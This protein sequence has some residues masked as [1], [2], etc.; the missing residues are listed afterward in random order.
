MDQHETA[1]SADPVV[2]APP[3]GAPAPR[4]LCTDC[5][6]SRTADAKRCGR[7]CQF[8]QPDYPAMETKVHGRPR[9]AARPD[10]TFFGPV[11]RMVRAE[12]SPPRLGAQWTG[13][14][15]RIAERLLET[16]AVEAVLTMAPDPDDSWK[17]MPVIIT[18]AEGMARARGMRMGYAPLL[19]LLEP[20]RDRGYKR[21]AV[22]GIPCQVFALRSIEE[23]LGLD[24]L[25]VIG[26]PCSDNTTTENFHKF[27][28]L[29]ADDP[30]TITYLEFRADYYVELRFTDGSKKEIPFLK[31]PISKLPSD[32]FPLTCRTCVDYTNVLADI[33][34]GYMGGEGQQW[35]LV[36]NER[37]EE[38]LNLLGDEVRLSEPGSAGKRKS[39]VAGFLANTERAAGGLPLRSMPDWLR[40][41]VG[42][43]MPKI[44]P[45]GLEFARSRLEMKACETV[46][47]LRRAMPRR[48]RHMVPAHVWAL[49]EPYGLKP[50]T[51]ELPRPPRES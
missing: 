22:I 5:G 8:I 15:T 18:A 43:L 9:D 20:V 28:D 51:D 2:W 41:I 4:D 26:T 6:L 3:L 40:P 25:Y 12:L 48:V 13:I 49:V 37:G 42:W 34:V 19:A 33:T 31:L 29:L 11:R 45:R 1:S 23:T 24:R 17:P 14:T 32:F 10:E 39:A 16:G 50:T 47:H 27:L 44:G 46:V 36:R 30:K 7:A 38:L 35:L 21:I